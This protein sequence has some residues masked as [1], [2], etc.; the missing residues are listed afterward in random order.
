MATTVQNLRSLEGASAQPELRTSEMLFFGFLAYAEAASLLFPLANAQRAAL[1]AINT[2]A[3]GV[4]LL[5]ARRLGSPRGTGPFELSPR[6]R[7]ALGAIRDWLPC[8]LIILAYRESALFSVPQPLD[9]LNRIF[10]RWDLMLLGN[11]WVTS[12][13]TAASPGLERYLEFAY[14]LCY[15]VVPLG[16]AVI[17][18]LSLGLDSPAAERALDRFWT[19]VLLALVSCYALFTFFPLMTPRLLFHDLPDSHFALR[20]LNLWL[21]GRFAGSGAVFPSGHVAGATAVALSVWKESRRWGALFLVIAASIAM[22]TVIGRY[23]YTADA[24][25]GMLIAAGAVSLSSFLL[26][27]REARQLL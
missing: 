1:L 22:A 8:F 18:S 21:L 10:E 13:R 20:R 25:A 11:F 23:H 17:Y 6:W 5:L 15:P 3:A 12:V 16:F 27:R 9:P 7:A 19:G 26:N 4:I 14:L 24:L 2:A